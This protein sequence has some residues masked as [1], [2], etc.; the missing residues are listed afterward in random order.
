MANGVLCLKGGNVEVEVKPFKKD[1]EVTPIS[2][3]FGEEWFEEKNVIYVP[4]YK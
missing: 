2:N 1:V 4:I 3:W